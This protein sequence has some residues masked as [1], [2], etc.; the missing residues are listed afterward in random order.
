MVANNDG[1]RAQGKLETVK[2]LQPAYDNSNYKAHKVAQLGHK[3]LIYPDD[4]QQTS[5]INNKKKPAT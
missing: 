4:Q 1:C 5:E 3:R 2:S